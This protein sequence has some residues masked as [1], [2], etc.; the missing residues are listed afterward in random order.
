MRIGGSIVKHFNDLDEW[1]ELVRDL[2]SS[3]VLYPYQHFEIP[4]EWITQFK[5][6]LVENNLVLGEVGIWNNPL[7]IE[8]E[9]KERAISECKKAL[10]LADELGARCCVNISGSKGEIWDGLYIDNYSDET[11]N[12]LVKVI[13]EIIDDVNPKHT[14]YTIECMPWM[15]PNT[16]DQYLRLIKDVNRKGFGVH[17]DYVNL[18]NSPRKYAF[19]M[20]FIKE[21]IIKLG[22]HIKS[23]HVK[24]IKLEEGFPINLKECPVGEGDLVMSD[25]LTWC[26]ELG[27]ISLFVEHLD[28]HNSY[29]DSIEFIRTIAKIEGIEI[30]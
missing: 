16:A 25:I 24:D 18:I 13:Q 2:N 26:A 10:K 29:K 1:L 12:E 4:N 14:F 3:T 7:D 11:Y 28:N 19:R 20:N 27:D 22:N 21:C 15:I 23:I 30:K 5:N 17:L 9:K 8:V 6:I